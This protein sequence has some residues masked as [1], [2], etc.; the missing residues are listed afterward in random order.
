MS[1]ICGIYHR[2][3][4]PADAADVGRMIDRLSHWQP[5]ATG[6]WQGRSVGLGHVA[7]WTTPE[8]VTETCPCEIAVAGVVV[9]ADARLDNR[10]E[11]LT[12][13]GLSAPSDRGIGDSE[14]I[15]RAYLKWGTKCVE[16]LVGDFAFALWDH[17]A[18][19]LFCARDALGVRPFYY[20]LDDRRFVF[21]TEIKAILTQPGISREADSLRYALFLLGGKLQRDHTQFLAV[22]ALEPACAIAISGSSVRQWRYWRLDPERELRLARDDDYVDAFDEVLQRAVDDRLRAHG[23]AASMLSGGLDSTV[24]TRFASRSAQL[25]GAG[26]TAYTWALRKDD[27]W[28]TSDERAYVE[29]YLAAHPLPHRYI[30]PDPR[31]VFDDSPEIRH[32]QDGPI[33]NLGIYATKP[34]FAAAQADGVRVLLMGDGGDET[35]SYDPPNYFLALTLAGRWRTLV[36]ET[37]EQASRIGAPWW[38][39][40]TNQVVRP[41]FTPDTWRDPF[42]VQDRLATFREVVAERRHGHLFV[43]EDLVQRSG[44]VDYLDRYRQKPERPWE[45]FA[46][47]RHI[48]GITG[49]ATFSEIATH[50]FN[51]SVLSH[52]ECRYPFMDRRLIEFCVALPL[53]Q[54]RRR[55]QSRRLL[56]RTAV[57]HLPGKI[58]NRTDKSATLADYDRGVRLAEARLH[59]LFQRWAGNPT[60]QSYL[61]VERLQESLPLIIAH[62]RA[63]TMGATRNFGGFCRAIFMGMFLE[64]APGAHQTPAT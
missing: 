27:D 19:Q 63:S 10:R 58:A 4:R 56:R 18:R 12:K 53:E 7:L 1:S 29:T 43:A 39:V 16:E 9:T 46:R 26:L 47:R 3:D 38:K 48:D 31:K 23:R 33:W 25:A 55:G 32:L 37:K 60:I 14:L 24:I 54:H 17:R 62:S 57:R 20:F 44:L 2:D 61:R 11:L 49:A 50:N 52:I 45:N 34:T 28:P 59:E 36:T 8:A 21:G 64:N 6:R 41:W 40:W 42:S 51:S 30:I 5:D 35:A 13:L 15:A 22:R